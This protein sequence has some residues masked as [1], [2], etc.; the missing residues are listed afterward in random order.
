MKVKIKKLFRYQ[1]GP[2]KVRELT[3][4]VYEVGKDISQHLCDSVLRYGK[5]EF[6]V[7]KKAPEKK[8]VEAPENK[9]GL[10]KPAMRGSSTRTKP[11]KR[12]NKKD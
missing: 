1:D 6:V 3:P 4:G 7:E 8:V 11:N 5:A 12:S 2:R 9:A 10:G